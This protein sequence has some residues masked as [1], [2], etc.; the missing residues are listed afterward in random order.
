M[1]SFHRDLL[2]LEDKGFHRR[3]DVFKQRQ[4]ELVKAG[5]QEEAAHNLQVRK[6]F[7][8]KKKNPLLL[9]FSR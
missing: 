7:F 2:E 9:V 5:V 4:G 8:F 3:L 6:V 1:L